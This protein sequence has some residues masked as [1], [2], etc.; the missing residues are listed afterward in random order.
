MDLTYDNPASWL[1]NILVAGKNIP[2]DKPCRR[3]WQQLLGVEEEALLMSRLGKVMELPH[4]IIALLQGHYPGRAA[5]WQHWHSQVNSGLMQQNLNGQWNSFI[6]PID[7]HSMTYLS[8]SADLLA[9]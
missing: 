2:V 4:Q 8:M 3:A 7:A 5:S 1:L 6:G 9:N